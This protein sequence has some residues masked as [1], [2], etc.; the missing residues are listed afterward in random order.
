M[1]KS[2]CCR[3]KDMSGVPLFIYKIKAIRSPKSLTI[4]IP[5]MIVISAMGLTLRK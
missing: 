5:H 3:C 2:R 4:V 1:I